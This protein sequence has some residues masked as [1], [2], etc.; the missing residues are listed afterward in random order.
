MFY[1]C[2][3]VIPGILEGTHA[4]PIFFV[5]PEIVVVATV[6]GYSMLLWYAFILA[7]I[8]VSFVILYKNHLFQFFIKVY[9]SL[10]SITHPE[11]NVIFD[12][13]KVFFASLFFSVFFALLSQI[14]LYLGVLSNP[15]TTPPFE[16]LE[17]WYLLYSFSVASFWEEIIVRLIFIGIPIA[18]INFIQNKSLKSL[19]AIFG[20]KNNGLEFNFLSIFL[21]LLSSAIFGLAHIYNWDFMKIAPAFV[22]GLGFGYLYVKHGLHAA[23]VLH[24]AFDYM[25]AVTILFELPNSVTIAISIIL[26]LWL[27]MGFVYFIRYSYRSVKFI[28]NVFSMKEIKKKN[29]EE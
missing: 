19:M 3:I 18:I 25:S 11:E 16:S 1:S 24:F 10:K 20:G 8:T 17:E 5:I 4:S 14:L 15:P 7:G 29:K 28:L 9:K 23:V 21:I 2:R 12:I 6:Q 27:G 13:S 26:I 22:S